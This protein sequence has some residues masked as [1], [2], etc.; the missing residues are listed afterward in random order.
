MKE[1]YVAV[2]KDIVPYT[3]R[4]YRVPD[5]SEGVAF[6]SNETILYEGE[7][8]YADS[9]MAAGIIQWHH[10]NDENIMFLFNP[11]NVPDEGETIF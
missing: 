7:W 9:L 10:N 2:N 8:S 11:D 3:F 6:V 1:T 5:L 4:V